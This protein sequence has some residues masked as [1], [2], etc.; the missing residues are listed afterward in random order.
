M[1]LK[2]VPFPTSFFHLAFLTF[3]S[4]SPFLSFFLPLT[5]T[6]S[7]SAHFQQITSKLVRLESQ[8]NSFI[9]K[10]PEQLEKFLSENLKEIHE[11]HF[12]MVEV[13]YM[14]CLMYGNVTG[15]QYKGLTPFHI[16]DD[17]GYFVSNV[18]WRLFRSS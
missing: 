2:K 11:D 12:L 13:K 7:F 18:R 16:D 10:I 3:F 17:K 9:K 8:L 4:P 15:Y 1:S 5:Q 14:L 6:F